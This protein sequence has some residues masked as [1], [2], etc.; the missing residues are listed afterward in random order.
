MWGEFFF[1]TDVRVVCCNKIKKHRYSIYKN[2]WFYHRKVS[3]ITILKII[4]L[5]LNNVPYKLIAHI[6]GLSRNRVTDIIYMFNYSS[7]LDYHLNTF[8]LGGT[9]NI[10]EID[11]SKFVRRKYNREHHVGR[12]WVFGGVEEE[13]R[14]FFSYLLKKE[15]K[16]H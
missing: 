2:T 8:K 14:R 13:L 3:I 11:E 15:T 10:I 1:Y 5:F 4:D 7:I 16:K 12:V 9:R 6:S